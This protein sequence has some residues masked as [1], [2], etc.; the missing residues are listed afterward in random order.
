MDQ[1]FA[2]A[3]IHPADHLLDRHVSLQRR[4]PQSQVVYAVEINPLLLRQAH[5]YRQLARAIA[6]ESDRETA[7]GDLQAG[8]NFFIADTEAP[9]FRFVDLGNQ[10]LAALLPVEIDAARRR[11]GADNLSCPVAQVAQH[12]GVGS[13]KPRLDLRSGRRAEYHAPHLVQDLGKAL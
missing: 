8:G 9:G 10:F 2:P 6:V 5:H 12:F 11:I 13:A 7:K 4:A 1:C 3:Q